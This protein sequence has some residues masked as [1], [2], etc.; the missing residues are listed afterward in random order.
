MTRAALAALLVSCAAPAGS[1]LRIKANH[2]ESMRGV[3]LEADAGPL[4]CNRE[5]ITGSHIVRWYCRIG[6]EPAQY[7]LGRRI[8]LNLR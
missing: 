7:E 8:V 1:V 6:E 4:T 3:R 5:A 2:F